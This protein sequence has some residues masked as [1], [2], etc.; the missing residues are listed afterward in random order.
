MSS[1][2]LTLIK[3]SWLNSGLELAT[4][5]HG[6]ST[7]NNAAPGRLHRMLVIMQQIKYACRGRRERKKDLG[8]FYLI[9]AIYT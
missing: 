6:H 9:S 3:S 1:L 4:L 8:T 5:T 7:S 2:C